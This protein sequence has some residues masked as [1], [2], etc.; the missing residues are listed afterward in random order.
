MAPVGWYLGVCII[1]FAYGASVVT[2]SLAGADQGNSDARAKALQKSMARIRLT[3]TDEPIPSGKVLLFPADGKAV[4]A[5]I[6][7]GDATVERLT[8]GRFRVAV[9]CT[10]LPEKYAEP[11]TSGLSVDVKEGMNEL[12]LDLAAVGIEAGAKAPNY[13][14][15]DASG[16]SHVGATAMEDKVVLLTFWSLQTMKSPATRAQF[17]QLRAIR[18]EFVGEKD[19]VIVSTCVDAYN[20]GS[21]NSKVWSDFLLGQGTVDYGDGKRRFIDDS[22]WWNTAEIDSSAFVKSSARF[23]V[24]RFPDAFLIGSDLRFRAVHISNDRLRDEVAKVYPKAARPR[25]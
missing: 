18:R 17:D 15:Y 8:P 20:E 13:C 14:F 10:E 23:G 4:E 24:A 1:A 19:F 7:D 12:K 3:M 9:R 2:H 5:R 6:R 25:G 16:G 21:E 22:R 11:A